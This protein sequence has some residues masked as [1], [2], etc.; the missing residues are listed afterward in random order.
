[1]TGLLFMDTFLYLTFSNS[2]Y[3]HSGTIFRVASV[4]N[5]TVNVT[6]IKARLSMSNSEKILGSI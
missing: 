4:F 3:C 5:M 6:L 1:M 2:Y